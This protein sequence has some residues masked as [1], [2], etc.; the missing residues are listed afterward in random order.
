MGKIES[1][2]HFAQ[3]AGYESFTEINFVE[4]EKCKQIIVDGYSAT[5][6]IKNISLLDPNKKFID[7]KTLIFFDEITTFLEIVTSLKFFKED[8]RFDVICSGSMLGVNYQKIESNSVGYKVDYEMFS[9]D[10]EEFLWAKGYN[11][12]TIANMLSH[13]NNLLPFSNLEMSIYKK[14]FFEY[15]TL[16][17]MPEV[18]RNYIEKGTFEGS[19]AIQ[20]QLVADYKEDIR[21]CVDGIDQTRILNV[22]NSIP[23]QLAKENKK[24]QISKIEKSARFRDY[25]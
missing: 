2:R 7:S 20:K 6:I 21:K 13:M 5:S 3:I 15:V 22:F 23:S 19:L 24:F 1:I 18:I 11:E 4:E 14:L 17:G 10:F 9:L 8:G 12:I 25:R 16:G